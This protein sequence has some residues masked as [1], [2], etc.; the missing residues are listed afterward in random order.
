MQYGQLQKSKSIN[1]L[2]LVE[3]QEEIALILTKGT[4]KDIRTIFIVHDKSLNELLAFLEPYYRPPSTTHMSAQI[5]KD[6]EDGKAAVEQQLHGNTSI[7]LTTDI[8]TCRA[9]V[10]YN[11]N[12]ILP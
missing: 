1:K 6:F 9:T 5:H 7:T 2:C 11:Y 12:C 8:R 3:T 4:W 10:F